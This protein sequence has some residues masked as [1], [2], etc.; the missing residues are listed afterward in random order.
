MISADPATLFINLR[1]NRNDNSELECKTA[2]TIKKRG[3]TSRIDL[4]IDWDGT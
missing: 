1:I 4:D 2:S 3:V